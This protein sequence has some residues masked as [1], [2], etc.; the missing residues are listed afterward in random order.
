MFPS[1][2]NE[3]EKPC[4]WHFISQPFVLVILPVLVSLD[5]AFHGLAAEVLFHTSFVGISGI[6]VVYPVRLRKNQLTFLY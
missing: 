5:E 6:R 1:V 2:R 4:S 3:S